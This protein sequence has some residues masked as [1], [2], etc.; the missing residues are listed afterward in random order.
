MIRRPPR[1]TL[2]PY[3]TLFRSQETTCTIAR[4]GEGVSQAIGVG[5]RDLSDEVGGLMML[6][7]L[8][9]L[10]ADAATAVVCVVGKPPGS[11]VA[12]RLEDAAASVAKPVVAYFAGASAP[13]AGPW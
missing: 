9:L 8:E 5:G 6:R 1:S 7:A 3:T 12:R 4:E 10:A 2:F 13:S 11:A